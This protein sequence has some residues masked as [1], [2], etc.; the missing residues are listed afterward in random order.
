MEQ[1]VSFERDI[2]P[3]WR[4]RDVSVF[5]LSSYDDVHDN[6]EAWIDGGMQP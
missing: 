3:R 5:D 6:A 1:G 4:D 2:C